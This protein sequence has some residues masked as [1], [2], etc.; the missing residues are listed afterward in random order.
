MLENTGYGLVLFEHETG[1]A[2]ATKLLSEF[3]HTRGAVPFILL[4][5][6]ADE[7]AVAEIIQAALMTAWSGRSLTE[8]TWR[9][10]SAAR[11]AC[12]R[13]SASGKWPNNR[14]ASSPAR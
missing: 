13:R 6:H 2:A 9:A 5:E 4:T 3:L 12:T 14:C 7:K 8:R 1:D 10:R 11:S